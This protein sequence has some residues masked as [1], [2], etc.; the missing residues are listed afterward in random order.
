MAAMVLVITT[1]GLL[2]AKRFVS[3]AMQDG[4]EAGV[5]SLSVTAGSDETSPHTE[6]GAHVS[7]QITN[8][9]SPSGKAS[10]SVSINDQP[11]AVPK[12]G[13][14]HKTIRTGDSTMHVDISS[15]GGA[16]NSSIS[17]FSTNVQS[18]TNSTFNHY[19]D[20]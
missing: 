7:Q 5:S 1:S 16:T 9:V 10:T 13:S 18:S 6:P 4:G 11:I 15:S 2:V 8:T 12:N 17:S 20:Q 14:V 3:A 19:S